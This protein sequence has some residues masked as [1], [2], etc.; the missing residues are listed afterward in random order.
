MP[1]YPQIILFGDSITEWSTGHTPGF[2]FHPAL[3]NIYIRKMDLINRGFAGYNTNNA[4]RVLPQFMPTP[5]QATVRLL[6]IFFGANDSCM[7][8][9]PSRQHV[10]LE[11]Y[12]D[13]LRTLIS[14]PAVKA[15]PDLKIILIITP[16]ID[17]RM[18]E[19]NGFGEGGRFAAVTAQYAQAGREVAE[20]TGVATCDLWTEFMKRAVGGNEDDI[21]SELLPGD[22]KADVNPKLQELFVDG[23]HFKPLAY[24]L[25]YEA[26]VNTIKQNFPELVPGGMSFVHPFWPDAPK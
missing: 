18:L 2:A 11:K 16:P 22:K 15:H 19:Q 4:V 12:K 21:P 6:T 23:L 24:E 1:P 20:D 9:Y 14:H 13:N 8:T 10:P 7:P 25:M 5:K 26:V 3:Q 17:E